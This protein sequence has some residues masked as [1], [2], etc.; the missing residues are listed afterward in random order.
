M[1][2]RGQLPIQSCQVFLPTYNILQCSDP[3]MFGPAGTQGEIPSN[4][5]FC[6]IWHSRISYQPGDLHNK[7]RRL[8]LQSDCEGGTDF[9][10]QGFKSAPSV[11]GPLFEVLCSNVWVKGLLEILTFTSMA[12]SAIVYLERIFLYTPK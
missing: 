10:F 11:N 6:M 3:P 2:T 8:P 5:K 12:S 7:I 1:Q 9:S 4:E